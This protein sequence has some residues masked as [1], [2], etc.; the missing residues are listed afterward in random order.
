[1]IFIIEPISKNYT[2]INNISIIGNLFENISLKSFNFQ[3][4]QKYIREYL[5]FLEKNK[6][7]KNQKTKENTKKSNY[8]F[9]ISLL[10]FI[11]LFDVCLFKSF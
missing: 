6:I 10:L 11:Y 1:M 2:Q 4:G 9:Y 7:K 3:N 8:I 5:D